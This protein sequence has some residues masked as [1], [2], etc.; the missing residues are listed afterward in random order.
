MDNNTFILKKYE[1]KKKRLP[2]ILTLD[3]FIKVI[4]E[5]KKPHHKLAFKLG[6]LCGLRISEILKLQ[7][8][9]IDYSRRLLFI[10]QSKWNKDR[11]VPFPKNLGKEL[12]HLP[13]KKCGVRALQ[14]SFKKKCN[15]VLGRDLHFHCL[16]HS[17]A[18]FYLDKGMNLVQ[19]QQL[20][21]HARLSTTSIYLHVNPKQTQ[22]AMDEIWGD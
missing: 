17:S 20:L 15:E 7:P 16:R 21:G 8:T 11:Y 5:T 19:V 10:R 4:K 14:I 22:N 18:S 13:I 12:K 1:G 2:S 3:E 9:D 6:F